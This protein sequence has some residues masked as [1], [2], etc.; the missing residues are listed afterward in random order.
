VSKACKTCCDRLSYVGHIPQKAAAHVYPLVSQVPTWGSVLCVTSILGEEV[1]DRGSTGYVMVGIVCQIVHNRSTSNKALVMISCV[2]Q[3]V[4]SESLCEM[5]EMNLM[6]QT[7]ETPESDRLGWSVRS[8]SLN[9]A[10][11]VAT[12]V[13]VRGGEHPSIACWSPSR[14]HNLIA[15]AIMV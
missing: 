9:A 1:H 8:A 11:D 10:P 6:L 4:S 13:H 2:D 5:A 14:A 15:A 3:H 12:F 7:R